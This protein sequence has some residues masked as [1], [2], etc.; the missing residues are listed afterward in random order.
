M[1]YWATR[2]RYQVGGRDCCL[3]DKKPRL[4][5]RDFRVKRGIWSGDIFNVL[6]EMPYKKFR[7]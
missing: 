1:A 5:K 4:S 2:D 6:A 3:W 7:R